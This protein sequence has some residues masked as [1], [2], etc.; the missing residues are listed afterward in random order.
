MNQN[1]TPA[2]ERERVRRRDSAPFAPA[3]DAEYLAGVRHTIT[4]AYDRLVRMKEESHN[5]SF[6]RGTSVWLDLPSLRVLRDAL[7]TPAGER[8]ALEE[9]RRLALSIV[10]SGYDSCYINR[11]TVERLAD[12]LLA[13][14]PAPAGGARERE[15]AVWPP[16]GICEA[17]GGPLGD[18]PEEREALEPIS[19]WGRERQRQAATCDPEWLLDMAKFGLLNQLRGEKVFPS[20]ILWLSSTKIKLTMDNGRVFTL[21]IREISHD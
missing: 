12:A 14:R 1:T 17:C 20:Q 16:K 8:E 9:A 15:D 6:V 18:Y 3:A 19:E 4:E 11:S 21:K 13:T 2:E 7:P 5:P 10:T